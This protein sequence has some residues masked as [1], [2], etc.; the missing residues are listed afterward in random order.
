MVSSLRSFGYAKVLLALMDVIVLMAVAAVILATRIKF[1][2]YGAATD[3]AVFF[4][5][6]SLAAVAI[7]RELHLY[8][9]KMFSTGA[10]QIVALGKGMLYVGILQ[11]VA[12]FLIKDHHFLDYSRAHILLYIAAGWGALAA[13]RVGLFRPAHRRI[14]GAS[15]SK[16]RVLAVGAGVAGQ[17]LATR[18]YEKP[19]LGLAL[20]GFVDD[21]PMKIGKQLLGSRIY[22]AVENIGSFVRELGAEEIYISINSIKYSRLLEIIE[23]CRQTGLPV[24]VTANHFQI[25]HNKIGTSE[26]DYIDSMTLRPRDLNSPSWRVKRLVDIVG[27]SILILFLSPLLVTIAVLIKLTSPGPVFYKSQVVGRKGTL[28]TWFKFRTMRVD[29]DESVH[30]EHL[31]KIITGNGTTEKLKNDPR[32]TSVGRILRRY[33]LDEL[34]QLFNVLR[35]E[36]SLIGPRPCLQYE[37]EHFDEWHKQRFHVTPGMTGLWQVFGRNQSDVTF[38]DSIILDLYYIQ[39]YSLWLDAKILIK[40]VPT[41][42]LG[43]GGA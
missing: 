31:K 17:E 34:P 1:F 21:D 13:V 40:T 28:F 26:F 32:V 19:E 12:V 14:Y 30:R 37:Y 25:V 5:V 6:S 27:S 15:T 10:D 8:K 16:R 3:Q 35:G 2:V 38:N 18:F 29:R 22:G 23:I 41:V 9:H 20:I 24:T 7:F 39:N 36:M 43:R 33:S 4:A 42:L 11:I